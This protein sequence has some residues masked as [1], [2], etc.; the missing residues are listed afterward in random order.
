[1]P[2]IGFPRFSREPPTKW[3]IIVNITHF[4][5]TAHIS[6]CGVLPFMPQDLP[7]PSWL[8]LPPTPN[9]PSN[10]TARVVN[11]NGV[12]LWYADYVPPTGGVKND[13]PNPVVCERTSL[14]FWRW[15]TDVDTRRQS[16]PLIVIHGA[17]AH[18]GYFGTIIEPLVH[19]GR[20]VI[21]VDLRG[22][23]SLFST[24]EIF[25]LSMPTGWWQGRSKIYNQPL[26]FELFA[27]DGICRG[28]LVWCLC[29]IPFL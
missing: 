16:T 9:L 25:L 20:R 19:T 10:N 13:A 3:T 12:D 22:H 23:V 17:L 24:C 7:Q 21:V 18:A 1:M 15:A 2:H 29:S 5:P 28:L 26:S 4:F 6:S 27:A 11:I 14:Q 8:T